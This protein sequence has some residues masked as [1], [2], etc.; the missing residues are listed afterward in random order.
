MCE[1]VHRV[2]YI[3]G[4]SE[5]QDEADDEGIN[6]RLAPAVHRDPD[7][8]RHVQDTEQRDE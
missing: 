8:Q 7:G 1:A 3:E 4:G 6:H 5:P 2:G